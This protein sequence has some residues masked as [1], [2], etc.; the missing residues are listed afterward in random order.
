MSRT[1]YFPLLALLLIVAC[2]TPEAKPVTVE[3][4]T[5]EIA[6]VFESPVA[7]TRRSLD[8]TQIVG[9]FTEHPE[10]RSDSAGIMEFYARRKFQYAWFVNDSL[11]ES[12]MGFLSLA[13][14]A[15]TAFREVATLRNRVQELLLG[16]RADG[17]KIMLCDTCQL[18]LELGLTAQFFRFADKKYGGIVGKD[19]RELDWF[20]PRRKKDFSRLIDSLAAGHMDLSLVEPLHPQYGKLKAFLKHLYDLETSVD[21]SPISLGELKKLEPGKEASFVPVMRHRL[22]VLGDLIEESDSKNL[23]ST[24][25]DSTLVQAV[26]HFQER[27]GL[28]P[29]GVIGAGVLKALNTTPQQKLRTLLVNMERLRWVQESYAP[30]LILVNIPEFKMH[31]FEGGEE[32][33]NMDVVVGTSATRTVIFSDTLSKIVFSPTWT[34]PASIVQ[35]EILPAIAKNPNYLAKKGMERIGGTDARPV[36]RQKPGA[37]NALG[38]VKF[39]FPN[40]YSIYFHDT[41]S[42]GGFAKDKRAFSHGCIRLSQPQELAEYLLRNDTAWTTEKIKQAMFSGKEKWVTMKEKRPVTIG[43][44]TAWVGT[45]GRLNFRDDVYGHDAKLAAELFFDPEAPPAPPIVTE[46]VQQ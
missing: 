28:S 34:I 4:Q 30:D 35:G 27:H 12:A 2:S 5:Q 17:R 21:W 29:D 8:S 42:K 14:G 9:F 1:F 32:A 25:Y 45:D 3:E 23:T 16:T 41:P 11:S 10:F 19:L 31:I 6:E 26:M 33:W 39:L 43:Y 44:F 36:I 37:G 24:E 15:D 13:N 20:I 40:S 38:R 7:Y 18:Q 22:M 46:Q